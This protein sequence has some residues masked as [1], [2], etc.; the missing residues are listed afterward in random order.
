MQ[1]GLGLQNYN[2]N[3]GHLPGSASVDPATHKVGGW[4]FLVRTLPFME[5][6]AEYNALYK[7][8]LTPE[9][10]R[11]GT[12]DQQEAATALL[13]R[14][15][16]VYVCLSNSNKKFLDPTARPPAGALTNYKAMGGTFA[17]ALAMAADD[18]RT[19]PYNPA[20]PKKFPDGVLFPGPGLRFSDITD[21]TSKTIAV[22]ETI[23]NVREPLD[24]GKGSDDVRPAQRH[25]R[26]DQ[27]IE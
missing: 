22:A 9:Q 4:S 20:N 2:N 24:G 17:A 14:P 26:P 27:A 1:M 3:L 11:G 15:M 21:E 13:D 6:A 5:F 16:E 8:E 7:D 10:P 23:D 18:T 19:P 12:A 25:G